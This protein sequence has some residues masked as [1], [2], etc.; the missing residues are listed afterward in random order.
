MS[1]VLS[2]N[3]HSRH[4][5]FLSLMIG[6]KRLSASSYQQVTKLNL[7]N[8]QLV[9]IDVFPFKS[10]PN[11]VSIDFSYNQLVSIDIE[12]AR[13]QPN[14]I[15][16]LNFS[17][18]KLETFLFVKDFRDLKSLNITENLLKTRNERFL[19]LQ[20][21]PKLESL[22]DANDNQYEDD[23][24]RLDQWNQLME[25]KI[26]RLWV[27][28]YNE[29]YRQETKPSIAKKILDEFRHSMFK[30]IEKHENF[31]QIHLSSVA[32][33]VIDKKIEE[34][35]TTTTTTSA[36]PTTRTTRRTLRTHLT[37]EFSQL[38]DTKSNLELYKY[39]RCHQHDE[40]DLNNVAVRMA[41]FEPS[42]EKPLLATC[43]GEKV[44]FIDCQTGDVTHIYEVANLR[45]TVNTGRKIKDKAPINLPKEYFSCL[46]WIQSHEHRVLAVGASNGHVYL[47]SA[48]HK[49]MFGHIEFAVNL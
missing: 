28:S 9:K 13:D 4:Q 37:S 44:C 38:C 49:L 11:L 30:I 22:I 43:G 8:L 45:S 21:C 15:E 5:E 3:K 36:T 29:K 1:S 35:S 7:S 41:A 32:N 26:D 34:L 40:N 46:C 2:P 39:I 19:L 17:H 42:V 31:F 16:N 20:L 6:A 18:N 24:L 27:M 47:I 10:L 12:W 48:Q 25:S 33:Y 23:Q 14:A